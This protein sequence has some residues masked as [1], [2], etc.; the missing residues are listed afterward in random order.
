MS[1]RLYFAGGREPL[2]PWQ[3]E[4]AERIFRDNIA[5]NAHP[6]SGGQFIDPEAT[7]ELKSQARRRGPPLDYPPCC[8]DPAPR[9]GDQ[10]GRIFCASCRRYLD[11]REE[12]PPDEP[13][14]KP[15]RTKRPQG[16]RPAVDGIDYD[17]SEQ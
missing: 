7:M 6:R 10:T 5:Y 2:E 8:D 12:P 16:F 17:S 1:T 14:L 13:S 9:I 3:R 15:A 11:H 4:M